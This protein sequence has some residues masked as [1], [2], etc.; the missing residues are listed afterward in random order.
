ML[1]Y[2]HISLILFLVFA[3]VSFSQK[4]PDTTLIISAVHLDRD[5]K[6][7]LQAPLDTFMLSVENYNPVFRESF[8]ATFLGNTGQAYQSNKFYDRQPVYPFLFAYPYQTYLSD[9]YK[10]SHFNTRKPFTEIR[11]LSSGTRE[12]SEQVLSAL[13]TQNINPKINIGIDYDLIASKGMYLDQSIASNRLG[14]FASYNTQSYSLYGSAHA[15]SIK[16]QE[17]GGIVSIDNF[18]DHQAEELN[19]RMFLD[20]ANSRLKNYTFFLTQK[21]IPVFRIK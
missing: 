11:Y 16:A 9:P 5:T 7:P 8:S 18:L 19:Y 13:H 17:S 3:S 10:I 15:N 20:N 2:F 21:Y 4:K 12:T 6:E 14:L 1:K